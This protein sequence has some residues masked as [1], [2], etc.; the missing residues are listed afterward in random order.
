MKHDTQDYYRIASGFYQFEDLPENYLELE[1]DEFHKLLEANAWQPFEGH[2]GENIAFFIEN[3][4]VEMEN[5]ARRERK[6]V[7]DEVRAKLNIES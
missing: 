4:S 2:K 7:L 3:L 1:D 5:I 6:K